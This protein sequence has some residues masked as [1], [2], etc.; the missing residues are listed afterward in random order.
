M[1]KAYPGLP[2]YTNPEKYGIIME[3]PYWF[4]KDTWSHKCVIGTQNL[5]PQTIEKWSRRMLF[6]FIGA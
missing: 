3:D 1:I 5:P 2:I 6:E 4:E